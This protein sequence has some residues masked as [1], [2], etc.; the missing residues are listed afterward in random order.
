VETLV[1]RLWEV[2]DTAT[3][4]LIATFYRQWL[5]RK[6]KRKVFKEEQGRVRA[7]HLAPYYRASFVLMD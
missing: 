2:D 5:E 6:N 3:P 1:M 4:I 7:E